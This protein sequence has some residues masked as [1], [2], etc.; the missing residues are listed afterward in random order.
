LEKLNVS[1]KRILFLCTGNSCRSQMAEAWANHLRGGKAQFYSAGTQKHGMNPYA[2]QVMEELGIDMGKHYSKTT[3][4]IQMNELD[5]I[6]TV[7]SHA[8]ENCP[9][10]AGANMI[11][12]GFDDPPK[13][14]ENLSDKEEILT[15]YRRVRDEI[16]SFIESIKLD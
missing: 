7:C 13:L 6:Y 2:I 16:R 15:V 1:Q 11:H 3:E 12:Q 4:D 5:I 9:Y 10:I 8:Q 14:C